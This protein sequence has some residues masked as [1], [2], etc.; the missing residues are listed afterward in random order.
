MGEDIQLIQHR[1]ENISRL[2]K[3]VDMI[4]AR[5]VPVKY[6]MED[7]MFVLK[8]SKSRAEYLPEHT[9]QDQTLIEQ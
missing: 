7:L 1:V 4:R 3:E 9:S 5:V 6:T 2:Q 8:E